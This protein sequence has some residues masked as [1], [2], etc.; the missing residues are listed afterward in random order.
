[1]L[2][3][4]SPYDGFGPLK[5]LLFHHP[6]LII[7]WLWK[8]R[9]GPSSNSKDMTH[10][11]CLGI[12]SI[13]K[14][15]MWLNCEPV[16]QRYF[17]SKI[18]IFF[19][20]TISVLS[21]SWSYYPGQISWELGLPRE[22]VIEEWFGRIARPCEDCGE[23]RKVSGFSVVPD[24]SSSLVLHIPSEKASVPSEDSSR[25]DLHGSQNRSDSWKVSGTESSRKE[26][27]WLWGWFEPDT[28]GI[29]TCRRRKRRARE[30]KK[31]SF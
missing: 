24:I 22:S 28:M 31:T 17:N 15:L 20:K 11:F 3:V 30:E 26:G 2:Q 1:M 7:G 21:E 13:P 9:Q 8:V 18:I 5:Y 4:L 16:N 25:Q 23:S 27:V 10:C 19:I 6:W 14:Q 29:T 12:A